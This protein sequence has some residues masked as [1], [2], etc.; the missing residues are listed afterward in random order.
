MMMDFFF[1]VFQYI[2]EHKDLYAEEEYYQLLD[3]WLEEYTEYLKN[4]VR[5]KKS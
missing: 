3:Q 1:D 4:L 5:Y 2:Q